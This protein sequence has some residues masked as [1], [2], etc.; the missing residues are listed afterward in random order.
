[1]GGVFPELIHSNGLQGVV[2]PAADLLGRDAQVL[3]GKGN[4]FLH[5]IGHDLVVRVLEHHA[6]GA[7]DRQEKFLV[8]GVHPIHIDPAS[9]GQKDG[10]EMLGQ[11]GLTAA[12]VA[13]HCHEGAFLNAQ[14][15]PVQHDGSHAL[16]GD[17]GE[18]DVLRVD[19]HIFHNKTTF[20]GVRN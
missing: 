12:V 18:A 2:H 6:H 17:I 9:G 16:G 10:I 14:R 15:D 19:D 13:Q 3:W 4:I 20:G 5:H 7:A 1:M 8:G 11:G